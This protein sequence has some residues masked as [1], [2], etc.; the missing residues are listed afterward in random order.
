MATEADI[1]SGLTNDGKAYMFQSLDAQ[2]NSRILFAILY[3]LYTGI[4]AV[5][6]W[7]I[8]IN[9]CWPIRRA[10]VVIIILLHALITISFAANWSYICTAF[11]DNEESFWTVFLVPSGVAV[12]FETGIAASMSTILT[13]LF[14]IWWC[15]MV[16]GRRWL[17]VLLPIL[18]L[19]SATAS[20]IIQVYLDHIKET[21]TVFITLYTSFTLATTLWCTLLIIYRIL[22][23]SRVK[24]RADGRLRV[25][26]HF[27]EVL[28]ESSALYSISMIAYLALTIREDSGLFYLDVI[29]TITKGIA[30]TLLVG[31]ITAGHRAHPHD[32]WQGSVVGSASIRSRS[33]EH[34]RT[35]FQEDARTS[36]TLDGDLEAQR[37]SSVTE[38]SPTLRSVSILADYAHVNTDISPETSPHLRDRSLRH[39]H[40]SLYEDATHGS[41]VVDEEIVLSR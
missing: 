9:K 5:T 6:L 2:L 17:V 27:I 36:P 8:F 35:S 33:Q 30:P 40:S 38:P 28:V 20:R 7:N 11:I 13:D 41:T 15:W 26:Q 25:Y 21:S 1:P 32:S 37:E 23:V 12:S 19:I 4:L 34:S 29:A 39:D 10:M 22:T 3:G 16:W 31:R 18:S 24:R 14:M